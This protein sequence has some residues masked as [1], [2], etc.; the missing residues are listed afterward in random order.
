M[1][2]ISFRLFNQGEYWEI[3]MN[4]PIKHWTFRFL[5]STALKVMEE[6]KTDF[7]PIYSEFLKIKEFYYISEVFK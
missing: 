7:A 1:I 2:P 4:S 5:D 6:V 3:D